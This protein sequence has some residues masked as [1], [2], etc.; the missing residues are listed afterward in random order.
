[1]IIL[2]E[3]YAAT[4]SVSVFIDYTA[5]D[6]RA[7]QRRI[8][9]TSFQILPKDIAKFLIRVQIWVVHPA[10]VDTVSGTLISAKNEIE[11]LFNLTLH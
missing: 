9:S 8:F 2:L 10:N 5:Y 6:C 4:P 3:S 11:L 1:M 7:D